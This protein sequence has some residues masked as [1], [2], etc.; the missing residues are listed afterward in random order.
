MKKWAFIFRLSVAIIFLSLS[1]AGPGDSFVTPEHY[2][3]LKQEA[4]TREKNEKKVNQEVPG[5]FQVHPGSGSGP[6]PPPRRKK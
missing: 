6:E 1:F 5:K 3:R 4:R 2:E